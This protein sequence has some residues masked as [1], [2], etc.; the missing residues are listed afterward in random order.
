M[1]YP[2]LTDRKQQQ[3]STA[4]WEYLFVFLKTPYYLL[5]SW[6]LSGAMQSFRFV[7]APSFLRFDRRWAFYR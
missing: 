2:M 3:R 6:D 4:R 5:A 1:E 7:S